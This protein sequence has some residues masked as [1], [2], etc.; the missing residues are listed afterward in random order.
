MYCLVCRTRDKNTTVIR[1]YHVHVYSLDE[2]ESEPNSVNWQ[3]ATSVCRKWA[4]TRVGGEYFPNSSIIKIHQS[5]RDLQVYTPARDVWCC[6]FIL[7]L[8]PLYI[9]FLTSRVRRRP[10]DKPLFAKKMFPIRFK[11]TCLPPPHCKSIVGDA[12]TRATSIIMNNYNIDVSVVILYFT[13]QSCNILQNVQKKKKKR[14]G[15]L[16]GPN[17]IIWCCYY[18]YYRRSGRARRTSI[19]RQTT[20]SEYCN[21]V[22]NFVRATMYY[23]VYTYIIIIYYN[24]L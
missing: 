22:T 23:V 18:Y 14:V 11:L 6:D 12:V 2:G 3:R 24:I 19:H 20:D 4:C 9:F 1:K 7:R 13:S 17:I 10:R 16:H 5:P 15:F 8:S 21:S